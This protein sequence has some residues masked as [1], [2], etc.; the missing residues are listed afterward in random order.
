MGVSIFVVAGALLVALLLLVG[1]SLGVFW[2]LKQ[3]AGSQLGVEF[4]APT[5][6]TL[7]PLREA[8][9]TLDQGLHAARQRKD[10]TRSGLVNEVANQRDHLVRQMDQLARARDQLQALSNSDVSGEAKRKLDA[11]DTRIS[12]ATRV[13]SQLAVKFAAPDIAEAAG[14]FE[15]EGIRETLRELAAIDK[16]LGESEQ[17][18]EDQRR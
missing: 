3:K 11:V 8:L 7:R 13:I 17:V 2:T 12:E 6:R 14:G 4:S 10:G 18:Q 9:A 15:D 16:T 1:L 5:R